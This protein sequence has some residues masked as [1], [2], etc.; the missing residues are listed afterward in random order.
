MRAVESAAHAHAS[1]KAA[2]YV[3]KFKGRPVL[4]RAADNVYHQAYTRY[5]VRLNGAGGVSVQR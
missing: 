4:A 1:A 5:L 2:A 3:A